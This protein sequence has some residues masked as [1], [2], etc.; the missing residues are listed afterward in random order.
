MQKN[1]IAKM[2]ASSVK[3]LFSTRNV[4]I[5][6]EHK[7]GH[8]QVSGKTQF[9]VGF[10]IIGFFSFV[11]YMSGSYMAAQS[12]LDDK[13]KKLQQVS[14][15]K[16]RI[17]EEFTLFRRDLSKLRETGKELKQYSQIMLDQHL[18][19][20]AGSS[21]S[22]IAQHALVNDGDSPM[23]SR[24][25]YLE[26]RIAEISGENE[27]LIAAIR[28]KTND[29][30]DFYEDL[31]S[32]TGLAVEPLEKQAMLKLKGKIASQDKLQQS[33]KT[34]NQGGP[35]I[36]FDASGF[37]DE[38]KLL[39]GNIDRLLVLRDIIETMPTRRPID[40]A[41]LMSPF[42]VRSDPFSGEAAMHTGLDLS[43]PDGARITAANSGRVMKSEMMGAY[44]NMI[45]IDH[46]Y[47][48]STRYGHLSKILVKEG[49]RVQ[50]GQIIGVQ[51]S[52]GR[53]TGAHLHYEV[54]LNDRP[55]N[56]AKFLKAGE[57]VSKE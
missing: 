35:F 2:L 21:S 11:S 3:R 19:A 14:T 5:V 26:N 32:S 22:L 13:E 25:N 23:L 27:Q 56:P 6:S 50:K 15:D 39:L 33:K 45:D 48:I 4:I 53:S 20:D 55:L 30:L 57:Y 16:N 28:E 37:S 7:I 49:Q 46:G 42:G 43:G 44:G 51:G 18:K 52:T 47:G 29:K 10:L 40:N 38:D 36:P 24:I 34:Q 17:D 1:S 8:H 9:L 12:L 31:I 41:K 54:R